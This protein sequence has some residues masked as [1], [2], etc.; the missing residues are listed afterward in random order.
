MDKNA[1]AKIQQTFPNDGA[2]IV[3][4]DIETTGLSHLTDVIVEVGIRITDA[5]L[6]TIDEYDVTVWDSPYYDRKFEELITRAEAGETGPNIVLDMHNKSR[7]WDSARGEGLTPADAEQ[8]VIDFL[9][10]HGV[11][12]E[13]LPMAGSSVHFDRMMITEQMPA[14][15][16]CFGHRNIDVSSIK[17]LCKILNPELYSKLDKYGPPKSEK[18]R[19]L[20]DLTDTIN[21]CAWYAEN[22]LYVT[23]T[24][25][26]YG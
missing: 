7:L 11:P 17:E 10:G 22:F 26:S 9:E 18:H 3:W 5:D 20:D 16:K 15:A 24:E 13:K 19:A 25:I 6:K 8:G 14:L 2:R 4:V 23:S 1:Q 12:A 21:E